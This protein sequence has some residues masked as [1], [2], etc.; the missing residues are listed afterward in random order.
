MLHVSK[1]FY[2]KVLVPKLVQVNTADL[3]IILRIS[4]KIILLIDSESRVKKK[5][6]S[7]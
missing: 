4:N 6:L 1:F 5:I 7:P 2:E 3:D